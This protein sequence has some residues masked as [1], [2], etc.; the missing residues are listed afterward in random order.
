M[1]QT[2]VICSEMFMFG[3]NS[4]F[5]VATKE[6]IGSCAEKMRVVLKNQVISF[7]KTNVKKTIRNLSVHQ[8]NINPYLTIIRQRVT[9]YFQ[10]TSSGGLITERKELIRKAIL[11]SLSW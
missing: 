11:F 10:K 1:Y 4:F 5:R 8:V 3:R 6:A 9:V 2:T 7:A